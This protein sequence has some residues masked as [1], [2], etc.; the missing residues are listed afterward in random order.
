[1]YSTTVRIELLARHIGG[2]A[3]SRKSF[4]ECGNLAKAHPLYEQRRIVAGE[5]IPASRHH[6]RGGVKVCRCQGRP[7]R[8]DIDR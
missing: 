5:E 2:R 3:L 6:T 8:E 4:K 7:G 1:M